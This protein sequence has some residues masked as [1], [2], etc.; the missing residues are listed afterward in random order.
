MSS[1]KDY[2]YV[3]GM[4]TSADPICRYRKIGR[5]NN[6]AQRRRQI[7]TGSPVPVVVHHVFE[8]SDFFHSC[9]FEAAC[10]A[11]FSSKR[12]EGEWFDVTN[13]EVAEFYISHLAEMEAIAVRLAAEA[14]EKEKQEKLA[15]EATR[16]RVKAERKVAAALAEARTNERRAAREA[17]ELASREFA[18]TFLEERLV[19][20]AGRSHSLAAHAALGI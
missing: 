8:F 9:F 17:D 14:A 1:G 3:M 2:V 16:L 20:L 11:E 13:S 6:V 15:Q 12:L 18:R 5:S 10:H 7:Q 4:D 19:G